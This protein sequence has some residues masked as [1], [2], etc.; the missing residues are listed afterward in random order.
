MRHTKLDSIYII[1]Y[2]FSV[3]LEKGESVS[4]ERTMKEQIILAALDEMHE[5]ALRFRMNDVTK[6]LHIS[7]TSLYKA[8]ASKTELINAVIDYMFDMFNAREATICSQDIP[9]RQKVT[10]L[11]QLYR[12]SFKNFD[13][14][15]YSDL[16]KDYTEE[17][18]R[19]MDFRRQKVDIIM[20]LL[21]EGIEKGELRAVNLDVMHCCLMAISEALFSEDFLRKSKL[22]YSMAMNCFGDMLFRGVEKNDIG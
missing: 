14:S 3:V 15:L 7:K 2:N 6:R 11:I 17:W 16:R 5:H 13:R 22:T 12:E 20:H 9:V 18:G 10:M 4:S 8:I 1:F 21:K 19:V